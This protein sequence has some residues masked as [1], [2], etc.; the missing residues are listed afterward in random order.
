MKLLYSYSMIEYSAKQQTI[1]ATLLIVLMQIF[2]LDINAN[3]TPTWITIDDQAY[4]YINNNHPTLLLESR[5]AL[6]D[7]NTSSPDKI[8]I[9][10]IPSDQLMNLSLV[11]HQK[12]N[13]CGGYFAHE[14]FETAQKFLESSTKISTTI[15][16][17]IDNEHSV[18]SL[19]NQL[20]SNHLSEVV[21][22]LSSYSTRY[23]QSTTG[24][25]AATW[26]HEHWQAMTT[27]R[28]DISVEYFNHNNWSQASVITTITGTS[29]PDEYVVIGGHL[30]S[31]N[32]RNPS[33]GLSPGMDDNASGIAVI[34]ELINMVV[35]SDFY[36]AR[37]VVIIGYAAEEV[38]LRGSAEIA[39]HFRSL[40]RNVAGVAQ[41]DMTSYFGT[42]QSD[43]VFISDYTDDAQTHFMTSLIDT[44]LTDLTYSFDYCGYACSDHASW[45]QMGY[46]A[47]FPFEARFGDSNPAI[48]TTSDHYY[49]VSHMVKF[50]RLAGT[51][52]AELAKGDIGN[53]VAKDVIGFAESEVTI[54]SG[55]SLTLTV[56]KAGGASEQVQI[57]YATASGTAIAGT[58]FTET[59]GT[60]TW[61]AGDNSAKTLT[62]TSN[63]TASDKRF[64]IN[65]FRVTEHAVLSSNDSVTVTLKGS[66]VIPPPIQ[67]AKSG[68]GTM[69]IIM[70]LLL[71]IYSAFN[72]RNRY[73]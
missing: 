4:Q 37:T 12:F 11:M 17:N 28:S 14:S 69:A 16:Y 20:S 41:F 10:Q 63:A 70:F 73:H 71:F 47:S 55:S 64:S 21:T 42:P 67:N 30:D 18:S 27:Q 3:S 1:R 59:T 22:Q 39:A 68:G 60:L 52:V 13:R 9:A 57:D 24:I 29:L 62:I 61:L 58:D 43:I 15:N 50:A 38:G 49:D 46:P 26:L 33:T 19:L 36:P 5:L 2:S 56:N 34:S 54:D 31:I 66:Q 72:Y 65:L 51:Y 53:S 23:Y 25:D 35:S 6:D 45:Y 8:Q 48:H 32:V 40:N 44:Y 7:E